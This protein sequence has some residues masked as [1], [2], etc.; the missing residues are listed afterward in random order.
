MS[1]RSKRHAAASAAETPSKVARISAST[2]VSNGAPVSP[3]PT[4]KAKG[5]E[6]RPCGVARVC[7]LL[8]HNFCMEM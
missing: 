6:V 3:P 2:H 4:K 8:R 1:T 7:L 5:E